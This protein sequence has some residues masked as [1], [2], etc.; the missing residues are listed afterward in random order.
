MCCER[1]IEKIASAS[2][3]RSGFSGAVD[4]LIFYDVC[5]GLVN[6]WIDHV[7]SLNIHKKPT[8]FIISKL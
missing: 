7:Y 2:A 1:V 5:I 4:E 6:P 8:K 3:C